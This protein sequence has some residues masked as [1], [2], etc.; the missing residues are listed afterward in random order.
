MSVKNTP[1]WSFSKLL[2][3]HTTTNI[4]LLT[5]ATFKPILVL[6]SVREVKMNVN[7]LCNGPQNQRRVLSVPI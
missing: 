4:F 5:N 2:L 7:M 1:W 6:Y 3:T